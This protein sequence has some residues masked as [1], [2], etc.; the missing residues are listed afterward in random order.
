[1][2]LHDA[3][4]DGAT[5]DEKF[6]TLDKDMLEPVPSNA[7]CSSTTA[8]GIDG[9]SGGVI[10]VAPDDTD[11]DAFVVPAEA[12]PKGRGTVGRM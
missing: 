12:A 9:N 3:G 1:M 7:A 5:D 10:E 4:E 8:T 6:I 2:V 11:E